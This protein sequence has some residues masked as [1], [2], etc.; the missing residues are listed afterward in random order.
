LNFSTTSLDR[1]GNLK[2]SDF[3]TKEVE[4]LNEG[5]NRLRNDFCLFLENEVKHEMSEMKYEMNEV[6]HELNSIK[7]VLTQ[8]KDAAG[9]LFM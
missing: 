4:K 6:K 7:G 5:I 9:M 8:T 1:I 2:E 3:P